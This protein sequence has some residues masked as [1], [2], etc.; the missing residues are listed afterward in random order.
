MSRQRAKDSRAKARRMSA[1]LLPGIAANKCATCGALNPTD[2]AAG[3]EQASTCAICGSPIQHR[4][5]NTLAFNPIVLSDDGATRVRGGRKR[6]ATSR[7]F[8][9][10]QVFSPRMRG[11]SSIEG[12]RPDRSNARNAEKPK[13]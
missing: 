5:V 11:E 12:T 13:G 8:F 6:T 9:A 7:D 1:D 2:M 3:E 10:E 4:T